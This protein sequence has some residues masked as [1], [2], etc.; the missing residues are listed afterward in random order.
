M[1]KGFGFAVDVDGAP[2]STH[3]LLFALGILKINS[4]FIPCTML[5]DTMQK[6]LPFVPSKQN[7]TCFLCSP[8]C[9]SFDSCGTHIS[10]FW[11]FPISC[12]R[13]E[14]ACWLTPYCSASCFCVGESSSSNNA[15]SFTSSNFFGCFPCSLSS[16]L[17]CVEDTAFETPKPSFIRILRW[18]MFTISFSK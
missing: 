7:V 15:C 16:F 13:L 17:F 18:N 10:V 4:C 3:Y 9:L 5:Y 14:I 6:H 12:G 11:I 8:I 1:S 2:G